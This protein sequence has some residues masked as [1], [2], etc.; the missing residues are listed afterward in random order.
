MCRITG[1][2]TSLSP[3]AGGGLRSLGGDAKGSKTRKEFQ[4]E[5]QHVRKS[6]ER[7]EL[8]RRAVSL[9]K[10]PVIALF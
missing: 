5:T 9:Q 3:G 2:G 6:Q 1:W 10:L 7:L 8:R 4:A